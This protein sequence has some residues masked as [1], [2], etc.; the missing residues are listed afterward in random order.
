MTGPLALHSADARRDNAAICI[1]SN[2]AFAN[3]FNRFRPEALSISQPL[4]KPAVAGKQHARPVLGQ[5][6]QVDKALNIFKEFVCHAPYI[7]RYRVHVN[8]RYNVKTC[9]LKLG[10]SGP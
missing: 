8:T 6:G 5:T 10:I 7:A 1:F 3:D 2:D 4:D 9:T